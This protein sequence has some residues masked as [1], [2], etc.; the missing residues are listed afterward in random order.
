[1]SIFAKTTTKYKNT[2]NL[3]S[4]LIKLRAGN[5]CEYCRSSR[6]LNSHHIFSK[7][8]F[9]TRWDERNGI[10]LCVNHHTFSSQFSAHLTPTEFTLWIIKKRGNDWYDKLLLRKQQIGKPDIK[11]TNMYLKQELKKYGH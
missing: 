6:N 11:L 4:R 2:D 7:S 8:N 3:W 5:E 1:M 9:S 10:S